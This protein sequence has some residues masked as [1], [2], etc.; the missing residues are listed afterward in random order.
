MDIILLILGL[1]LLILGI[2]G[3]FVPLVPGPILSW[4][5]LLVLQLTSVLEFDWAFLGITFAITIVVGLMDYYIPAI[6]AKKFGGT[7]YGIIGTQVGLLLGLL[8]FPPFGMLIGAMVGAFVGEL[9]KNQKEVQTA[10]KAAFGSFLGFLSSTFL[11]IC[12]TVTFLVMYL[13]IAW[14][15]KNY[16]IQGVKDAFSFLA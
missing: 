13:N 1:F 2:I 15:H 16:F 11:K 14:S 5:G 8:L 7:R 9:I 3:C 4:G 12:L 10:G 6:G